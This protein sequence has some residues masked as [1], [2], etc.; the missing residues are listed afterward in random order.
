MDIEIRPDGGDMYLQIAGGIR[1][2]LIAGEFVAGDRLPPARELAA[3]LGVN[4]HTV[5]RAYAELVAD[6]LIDLRR[7][8]GAT[9]LMNSDGYAR[10]ETLIAELAVEARRLGM[11]SAEIVDRVSRHFDRA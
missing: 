10:I 3:G 11:S 4:F 5:R 9:V 6:G 7:G 8:R 1:R 2:A